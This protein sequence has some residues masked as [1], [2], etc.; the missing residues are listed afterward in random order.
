MAI[1][2]KKQR[3]GW[4]YTHERVELFLKKWN[5]ISR[6]KEKEKKTKA[7]MEGV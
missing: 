6:A 4:G 3:S 7:Q 1:F 5:S 2:L